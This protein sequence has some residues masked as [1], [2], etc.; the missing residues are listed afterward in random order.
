MPIF[1]YNCMDCHEHFEELV[2]LTKSDKVKCPKCGKSN[3]K[4]M[5]STFASSE[6]KTSVPVNRGCGSGKFT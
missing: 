2:S 3:T 1:E 4:K 5:F 6:K